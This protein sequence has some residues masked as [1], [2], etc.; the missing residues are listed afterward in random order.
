NHAFQRW[1]VHCMGASGVPGLHPIAVQ[2]LHAIAH[3]DREKTLSELCM[4]FNIED[5][6]VV[7]YGIKRLT[8]M[9]LVESRRRGK[10]KGV[11]ATM[12]GKEVC[13]RYHEVREALLIAGMKRL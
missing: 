7:T 2:I 10:E 1:M 13:R 8:A 3:R 4:M 12:K 9:G 6:H 11:L 5:T